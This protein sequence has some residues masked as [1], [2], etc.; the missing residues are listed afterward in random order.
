[1]LRVFK[2]RELR[3]IFGPNSNEISG[4]WENCIMMSFVIYI[5]Q[6]LF[7]CQI[8]GHEMGRSRGTQCENKSAFRAWVRKP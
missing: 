7:G 5:V 8:N 1:M 6:K 4:G 2:N 3:K